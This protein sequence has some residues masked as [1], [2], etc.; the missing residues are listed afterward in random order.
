MPLPRPQPPFWLPDT[1]VPAMRD[2]DTRYMAPVWAPTFAVLFAIVLDTIEIGNSVTIEPD[3]VV[4]KLF[5]TVEFVIA[6]GLSWPVAPVTDQLMSAL[7]VL[8]ELPLKV[9][10]SR[11]VVATL[12]L[13]ADPS[14]SRLPDR[15]HGWG[16]PKARPRPKQLPCCC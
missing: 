3:P 6:T 2:P 9:D 14:R 4:V 10:E 5:E 13:V 11:V 7:A 1:I 16:F 8:A 12:L 15:F